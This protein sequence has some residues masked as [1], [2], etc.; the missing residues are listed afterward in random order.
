MKRS[1]FFLIGFLVL[2]SCNQNRVKSSIPIKD[3]SLKNVDSIKR[4]S[5]SGEKFT[6]LELY[7]MIDS[8][9]D[10]GNR[11]AYNNVS[12]YYLINEM[13]ELFLFP[14]FIMANKY[15]EPAAYFDVYDI[16]C[17][18]RYDSHLERIDSATRTIAL[19]YLMK[20]Y[21]LGFRAAKYEV[22]EK[23]IKRKLIIPK[24]KDI[25]N[26]NPVLR[27]VRIKATER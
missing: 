2:L 26:L 18:Q 5:Y 14:A 20:S 19:Y 21:E 1:L 3:S 7:K 10:Q 6:Q 9:L 27:S 25:L 8:A 13:D 15:H 11:K 22:E 16:L 12:N 4:I 24:S 17:N 23:F